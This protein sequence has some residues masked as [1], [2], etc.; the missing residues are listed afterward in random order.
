M[1]FGTGITARASV[2]SFEVNSPTRESASS[3]RAVKGSHTPG[4]CESLIR[5]DDRCT[6]LRAAKAPD[7]VGCE[8]AI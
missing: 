8:P 3:P 6:T 1:S 2:R 7:N 5:H 4:R